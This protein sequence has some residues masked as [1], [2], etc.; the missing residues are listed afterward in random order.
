M[1]GDLLFNGI[2]QSAQRSNLAG[3]VQTDASWRINDAHTLRGG[4]LG[5]IE[6]T[7]S[8][9]FS[10]VLPVDGDGVQTSDQPI[11]I[12]DNSGKTGGLYGVDGQDEWR[13]LPAL[14][15]NYGLRFDGVDEYTN[16]TQVSPRINAVW[17]ATDTTTIYAG[18]SR[19]FVPPPFELCL[20]DQHQPLRRHD[21]GAIGD[22]G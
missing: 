4:F 15:V 16:E 3:G 9:T 12:R 17:K 14:T 21:G 1:Y 8:D 2:S 11:G 5:Q 13:I 19:Y 22:A 7:S 18:Y 20:T 10:E 6:H